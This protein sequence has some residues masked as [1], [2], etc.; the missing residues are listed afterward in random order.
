MAWLRLRRVSF[1][2]GRCGVD[3]FMTPGLTVGAWWPTSMRWG[4]YG[5]MNNSGASA[6]GNG[7]TAARFWLI[8]SLDFTG[9]YR[10]VPGF[11]GFY[12]VLLDF[13]HLT[14][15][16]DDCDVA[17]RNH[18]VH[19]KDGVLG[20]T[21]YNWICQIILHSFLQDSIRFCWA[22][23]GLRAQMFKFLCN[24]T[25]FL[26]ILLILLL[27]FKEC[28]QILQIIR[29]HFIT[30]FCVFSSLLGFTNFFE[31]SLIGLDSTTVYRI[32][33]N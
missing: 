20:W 21:S 24:F 19:G 27:V 3:F 32:F 4:R 16:K 9:F 12:R 8:S 31:F 22:A 15:V 11:T 1:E 29:F 23:Q 26:R 18:V 10:V 30:E 5:L 28:W 7:P 13:I 14:L 17:W 25:E 6:K 2:V 33:W